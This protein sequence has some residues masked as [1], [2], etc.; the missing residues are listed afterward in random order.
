MGGHE[1]KLGGMGGHENKLGGMGGHE[2]KLGGMGGHENKLGGMGGHEN[3]LGGGR[4]EGKGQW[5]EAR[6]GKPDTHEP[7]IGSLCEH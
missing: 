3:K 7:N 4:C 5:E 1:N 2:N 6:T